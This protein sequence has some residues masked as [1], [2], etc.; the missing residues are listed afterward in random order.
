MEIGGAAQGFAGDE[1]WSNGELEGKADK[2]P[3]SLRKLRCGKR[4]GSPPVQGATV[5]HR[6]ARLY[7]TAIQGATQ[8]ATKCY[9][10][11]YSPT[12]TGQHFH[13]RILRAACK[14]LVLYELFS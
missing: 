13:F 12:G 11:C 3:P 4:G 10:G 14:T 2:D 8:G 1:C 6:L 7:K 9:T 5:L